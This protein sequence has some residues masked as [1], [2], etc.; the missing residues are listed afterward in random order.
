MSA[1]LGRARA[2]ARALWRFLVGETP[3]FALVVSGLVVYALLLRHVRPAVV[4]GLPS[5]VVTVMAVSVHVRRR[6]AP[7]R[8]PAP[9]ATAPA[10]PDATSASV[11][12]GPA[13]PS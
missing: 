10:A 1:A 3:E 5:L 13:L 6:S 4:Y 9:E 12:G 11:T 7:G 8:V 2:G